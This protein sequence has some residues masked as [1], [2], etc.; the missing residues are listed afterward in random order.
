MYSIAY[1][2][3]TLQ[4]CSAP[5]QINHCSFYNLI[6]RPKEATDEHQKNKLEPD[7]R[8][9]GVLTNESIKTHRN[10]SETMSI[11]AMNYSAVAL[12]CQG[13]HGEALNMLGQAL[14]SIR[15]RVDGTMME[16]EGAPAT[17]TCSLSSLPIAKGLDDDSSSSAHNLFCFYN[18][19]FVFPDTSTSSTIS[20][21]MDYSK[22]ILFNMALTLHHKG[23]VSTSGC[24]KT[25]TQ[26]LQKALS[27]YK[28]IVALQCK[29]ATSSTSSFINTLLMAVYS[30]MGHIYSHFFA[31]QEA[32]QCRYMINAMLLQSSSRRNMSSED[33]VVFFLNTDAT[34]SLK[35]DWA[36][37]A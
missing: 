16:V 14:H 6:L 18:R 24:D 26:Y 31:R 29:K 4:V 22:V 17:V 20:K 1:R 36:P 19:A 21:Q 34:S 28:T 7:G 10:H 5:G 30:N 3:C 33:Y 15:D 37:A 32:I 8:Y 11:V 13:K 25:T 2:N 23:L 12:L 9:P 27:I 35:M